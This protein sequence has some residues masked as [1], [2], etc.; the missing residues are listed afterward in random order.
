[1][2]I[3]KHRLSHGDDHYG[4]FVRALKYRSVWLDGW[5]DI[6]VAISRLG[7]TFKQEVLSNVDLSKSLHIAD[8]GCGTGMLMYE[9]GKCYPELE[10]TGIDPDPGMLRRAKRRTSRL[11]NRVSLIRGFSTQI[12]LPDQ[13]VDTC[14]STLTF[15]HLSQTQKQK[16]ATEIYRVLKSGGQLVVADFRRI[17]FPSFSRLFLLENS[18]YLR[19]NFEGAVS[20]A[21]SQAGFVAIR[22]I[23]R[24]FS[25]VSIIVAEKN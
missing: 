4:T 12:D 7:R 11:E 2:T 8:I 3:L 10:M 20:I 13:S 18:E 14:F 23:R 19:G 6:L 24:P 1:M 25:L 21:I 5:Y 17:R 15:H 16:T 22:E 9:A